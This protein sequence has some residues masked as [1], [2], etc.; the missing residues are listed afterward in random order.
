MRIK[1]KIVEVYD[2]LDKSII[3][4]IDKA[5]SDKKDVYISTYS[6]YNNKWGN[7]KTEFL[8]HDPKEH[9][10]WDGKH[11]DGKPYYEYDNGLT[12]VVF[13]VTIE[14]SIPIHSTP[15]RVL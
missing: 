6:G 14:D 11:G 7:A 5:R 1:K 13:G 12:V 4:V 3:G 15:G 2:M 8:M 10:N 9:W